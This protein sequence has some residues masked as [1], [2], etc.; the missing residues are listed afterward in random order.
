[1]V[2]VPA[3]SGCKVSGAT[4][5]PQQDKALLL[6]SFRYLSDDHFWFSFFHEVGHLLLHGIEKIFLEG[7]D[8]INQND[9]EEA[10]K[11]A[12]ELLIPL[13]IRKP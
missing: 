3:P 6:L 4:L 9:E 1:M 10:N 13:S 2:I 5:F 8:E 7:V 11:F 12:A